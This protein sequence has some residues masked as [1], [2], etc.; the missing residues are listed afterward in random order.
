MPRTVADGLI[1]IARKIDP[2]GTAQA[3]VGWLERHLD[4]WDVPT[5]HNLADLAL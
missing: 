5:G 1:G 3:L 4:P 2:L